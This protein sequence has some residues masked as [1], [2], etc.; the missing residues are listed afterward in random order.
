MHTNSK[1]HLD[2]SSICVTVAAGVKGLC[3]FLFFLG[4]GG[5]CQD[6]RR[7]GGGYD[8]HVSVTAVP[9]ANGAVPVGHHDE[10]GTGLRGRKRGACCG[11]LGG[12]SGGRRKEA[13]QSDQNK[14][15]GASQGVRYL[16]SNL[17]C[18][19]KRHCKT[20]DHHV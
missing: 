10:S 4:G 14:E 1:Q 5:L 11:H 16:I 8:G 20:C 13:R 12:G 19:I 7:G 2:S 15:R 17:N 18:K 6:T 9:A 3:L